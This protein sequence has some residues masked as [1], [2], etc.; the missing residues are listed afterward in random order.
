M[1]SISPLGNPAQE[2]HQSS[3]LDQPPLIHTETVATDD[4]GRFSFNMTKLD[5][6]DGKHMSLN[7]MEIS[8]TSASPFHV[9]I[10]S[11]RLHFLALA[12]FLNFG[13]C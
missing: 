6:G 5:D 12:A 9:L 8:Y 10:K 11:N 3:S 4:V 7:G 2:L 1:G 13:L